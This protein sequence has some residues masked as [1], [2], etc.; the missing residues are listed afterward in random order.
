MRVVAVRTG[1]DGPDVRGA[2]KGQQAIDDESEQWQ[3]RHQPDP[4][5]GEDVPEGRENAG[6]AALD[7]LA[8]LLVREDCGRIDE[9]V[10]RPLGVL[11]EV[12]RF[13]GGH[14]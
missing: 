5:G 1:V 12:A 6:E 3:D 14:G 13:V 8:D 10:V 4:L 7:R 2:C 9:A 11:E